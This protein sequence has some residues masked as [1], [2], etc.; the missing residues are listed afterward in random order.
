[1]KVTVDTYV[2][3]HGDTYHTFTSAQQSE[4]QLNSRPTN[5]RPALVQKSMMQGCFA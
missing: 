5:N 3:L 1:M 4:P 2:G